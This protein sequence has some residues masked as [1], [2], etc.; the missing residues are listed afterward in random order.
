MSWPA[1]VRAP[2]T[3]VWTALMNWQYRPGQH[4]L[5]VLKQ[6]VPSDKH[7]RASIAA[8]PTDD[9]AAETRTA[10]SATQKKAEG[11]MLQFE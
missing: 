7:W 5:N 3:P 8:L 9:G 11:R 6:S 4:V 1:S 10:A 2:L